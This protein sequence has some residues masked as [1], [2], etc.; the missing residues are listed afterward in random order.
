MGS[1]TKMGTED[2]FRSGRAD[3]REASQ[4]LLRAMQLLERSMARAAGEPEEGPRL[5][6]LAK[7]APAATDSS[8]ATASPPRWTPSVHE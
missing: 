8:V 1:G 3:V 4:C 6:L 7:R 2:G 5:L